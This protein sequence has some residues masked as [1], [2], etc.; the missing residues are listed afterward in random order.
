[1]HVFNRKTF[2]LILTFIIAL[3]NFDC[4]IISCNFKHCLWQLKK[5]QRTENIIAGQAATC[6]LIH[7]KQ[8]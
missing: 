4:V 6:D 1:M 8:T 5:G 2:N 7:N 3:L